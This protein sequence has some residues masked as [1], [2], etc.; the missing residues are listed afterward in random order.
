M[1]TPANPVAA[2]GET[3]GA[4]L[5]D[6]LLGAG[7]AT[8]LLVPKLLHL[9]NNRRAWYAFRVMLGLSG[10]SLVVLPIG[11]SN[12]YYLAVFGLALFIAGILLPPAKHS[13]NVEKKARELGALVVVNGGGYQAVNEP[14]SPVQL[15]VA[16]ETIWVLDSR[17]RPLLVIPT[18][19]ISSVRAEETRKHWQLRI[20]WGGNFGEFSYRGA[21]AEHLA[22]VAETTLQSAMRPTLPV[23]P[24]SRAASA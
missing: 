12:N 14:A 7:F 21:F 17:L 20:E 4:K 22:R 2:K 8:V 24:K 3:I 6:V 1:S 13:Y 15:F 19:Q 9:R 18:N 23:I 5:R 11:L 10:A 16:R